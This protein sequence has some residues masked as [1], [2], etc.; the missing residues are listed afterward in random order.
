MRATETSK[1]LER[2]DLA[3]C[4][5]MHQTC[6]KMGQTSA[7]IIDYSA[8]IDCGA[9]CLH[10]SREQSQ[11]N[12]IQHKDRMSTKIA[13]GVGVVALSL[14]SPLAQAGFD[15]AV[16][17]NVGAADTSEGGG[18][19]TFYTKID[20]TAAD[21][22]TG[23]NAGK[24][25]AETGGSRVYSVCLDVGNWLGG[26]YFAV[27]SPD[28]LTGI[29]PKWGNPADGTVAADA[30][31]AAANIAYRA[32]VDGKLSDAAGYQSLQLAVWEALYDTPAG[33]GFGS[34]RF[35]A[36]NP[37]QLATDMLAY[38]ADPIALKYNIL[39]PVQWDAQ[40]KT[41]TE[42]DNQ[43]LMFSF[44]DITP[45]PEPATVFAGALLLLP[46]GVSTFRIL[47]RQA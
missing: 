33:L 28:T 41:W 22:Y 29:T 8:G 4:L 46:L 21:P 26:G 45:A 43:E 17:Y 13:F 39:V 37:T 9:L 11:H 34:G 24:L 1:P 35:Q 27:A 12:Q 7:F 23:V 44:G 18:L 19:T 38:A 30:I 2:M 25:Y 6:L 16:L 32:Q 42:R 20:K 40:A 5:K 3:G 14:L 15:T 36:A 31:L 10:G 47:R